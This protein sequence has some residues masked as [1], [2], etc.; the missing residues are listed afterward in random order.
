MIV[1]ADIEGLI[2][3]WNYKKELI[4]EIKF[5][6]TVS[7]V[8]F[9]NKEGDILVGHNGQLSKIAVADYNPFQF[10]SMLGCTNEELNCLK[11]AAILV[12]PD[13]FL[14]CK[15]RDMDLLPNDNNKT[16]K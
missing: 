12:E 4:R 2:K 7:A 16:H 1:T 6:E 8:S 3:I 13:Y 15:E 10:P 9:M 14:K 5:Y 11:A